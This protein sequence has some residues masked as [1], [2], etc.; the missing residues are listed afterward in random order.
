M[1]MV[2]QSTPYSKN[3]LNT[4][5]IISLLTSTASVY[6]GI[7]FIS[8]N[9]AALFQGS[10]YY[11][12]INFLSKLYSSTYQNPELPY[13]SYNC[14]CQCGILR[15]LDFLFRNGDAKHYKEQIPQNIHRCVSVLQKGQIYYS[16]RDGRAPQQDEAHGSAHYQTH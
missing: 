12:G 8:D 4:L 10:S 15:L 2:K 3:H 1:I 11:Q 13:F 16:K 6:F 14:I 5:E 9:M 7:F